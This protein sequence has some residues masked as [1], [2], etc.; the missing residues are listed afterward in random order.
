MRQYSSAGAWVL[1]VAC[2]SIAGLLGCG[3]STL[4]APPQ[5]TSPIPDTQRILLL[6]SRLPAFVTYDV[7]GPL[8]VRKT[9]YGGPEWA[10]ERLAQEAR[11]VGAN[12]VVGVEVSFAPSWAGWATPH[13]KGTAVRI[14]TPSL[15]ELAALPELKAEWW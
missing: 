14:I 12:A 2:L 4:Q 10:L 3:G 1:A 11:S 8:A 6:R 13:G 5:A 15:E 7:L 9:S